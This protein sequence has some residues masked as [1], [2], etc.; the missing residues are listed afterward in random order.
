MFYETEESEKFL[1]NGYVTDI[2]YNSGVTI[3]EQNGKEV[4]KFGEEL[5]GEDLVDS[6]RSHTA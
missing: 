6:F 4:Y 1:D 5:K 3:R 2:T